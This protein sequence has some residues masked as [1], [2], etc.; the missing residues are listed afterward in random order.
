MYTAPK[1]K[2]MRNKKN[3]TQFTVSTQTFSN[4]LITMANIT[5]QLQDS[6]KWLIPNIAGI[7][8]I[9]S[10]KLYCDLT[11]ADTGSY[12][13]GIR[14]FYPNGCIDEKFKNLKV[15]KGTNFG[16]LGNQGDA[17][18]R[19]YSVT[20][21]LTTGLFTLRFGFNATT[22]ARV[23]ILNMLTNFNVLT[24]NFQG[25]SLYTSNYNITSQPAGTYLIILE[26][27][28]GNYVAKVIKQ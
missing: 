28:K 12:N 15:V 16:N 27:A 6:V 18:L 17:F 10:S 14:A 7:Q 25:S 3:N 4:Q 8:I 9:N 22:V 20:P 5:T 19:S 26:T 2:N 21:S 11:I 1:N 13:V 24:A 23:R